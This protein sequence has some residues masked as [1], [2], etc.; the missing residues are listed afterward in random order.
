MAR[1]YPPLL[2]AVIICVLMTVFAVAYALLAN[3]GTPPPAPPPAGTPGTPVATGA[4][5]QVAS[6][7]FS[8]SVAPSS[9][10]ARPGDTVRFTLTVHPE[11][12]FSAPIDLSVSATALGG[13]YRENRDLGTISAPYPPLTYEAAA[14]D[15]PPFVSTATV[16]AVVT[17][18]GGGIVRTERV[19][20]VI[21]R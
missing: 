15:L 4:P 18:T 19:Q 21:R 11:G 9:A 6:R 20:V 3:E 5:V 16:D 10:T 12:G 17:A 1:E 8:I 14:P 2:T 7:T 13:V